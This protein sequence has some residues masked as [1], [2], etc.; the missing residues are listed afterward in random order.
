MTIRWNFQSSNKLTGNQDVKYMRKTVFILVG[1]K[2]SGKTFIGNLI[3]KDLGIN[4]FRVEDVWLKI[5]AD[6][7]SDEY[8]KEGF[9]RVENEIDD[10]FKTNDTLIIE[11]TASHKEFLR[12]LG[13]L[14][15]RYTV[16]LI[17]IE[18]PEDLCMKRIKER[19]QSIHVAI[20]DDMIENINNITL[21]DEKEFDLIID[22]MSSRDID[23]IS[24][25]RTLL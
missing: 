8:I 9:S 1:K 11:S 6:K 21:L 5:K 3:E 17:K 4:F 25:F 7:L 22:N 19:D 16:L 13:K 10:K 24:Q 20:S 23:I 14:K 18:A 2:G 15:S 12:H